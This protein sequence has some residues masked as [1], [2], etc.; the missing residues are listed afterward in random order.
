MC[1][2]SYSTYKP[3]VPLVKD[4]S[5]RSEQQLMKESDDVYYPLCNKYHD[6]HSQTKSPAGKDINKFTNPLFNKKR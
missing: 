4:L 3:E 5:T 6:G 1:S 2:L